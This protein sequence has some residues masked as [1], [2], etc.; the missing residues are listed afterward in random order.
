[1]CASLGASTAGGTLLVTV[2]VA[3]NGFAGVQPA[4]MAATTK[5]TVSPIRRM[6]C[7]SLLSSKEL[8]VPLAVE[9]GDP[10]GFGGIFHACRW[11][12]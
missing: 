9:A 6:S 11:P 8:S 4:A 1:M 3:G 5:A 12:E 7:L 2:V 10:L